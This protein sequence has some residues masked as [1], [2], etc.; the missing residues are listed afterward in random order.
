[1]TVPAEPLS[2][3]RRLAAEATGS[4]FLF[5]AVIGSGVMAEALAGGN[6]AVALL[7]NT[8]ATGAML[9]VLIVMLGPVSGAHFNP[10]VS[11]VMALRRELDWG[12]AAAFVLAQLCGGLLGALAAHL[13][14]GLPILQVSLHTRSGIGQWSGEAIATF[15]LILTIVGTIEHR[16]SWVAPSVA[17]YIVSAYWFTSSTS[18]A[19]PAI[20]IVRSLTDSFAGIAPRDVPMFV[21]AQLVGALAGMA[22]GAALFGRSAR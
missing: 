19:N 6:I 16:R 3:R 4:F 10:A 9:F 5:A 8:L 11:M 14:F 20:T 2:V 18:F 22:A 1:M 17:L 15:G 12:E 7:G 21:A 13:M